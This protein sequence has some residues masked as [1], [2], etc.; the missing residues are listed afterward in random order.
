LHS[1]LAA[2]PTAHEAKRAASVA[3]HTERSIADPTGR[4]TVEVRNRLSD[5]I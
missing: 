4:P 2:D 5:F 3:L 1:P